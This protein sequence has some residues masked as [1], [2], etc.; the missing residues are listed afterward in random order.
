M[1]DVLLAPGS[2]IRLVPTFSLVLNPMGCACLPACPFAFLQRGRS[3]DPQ[4]ELIPRCF[5][6]AIHL[7]AGLILA[8]RGSLP[9]CA[10]QPVPGGRTDEPCCLIPVFR[11]I[12]YVGT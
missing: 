7:H 2:P 3:N 10:C 9:V 1:V 12:Q 6:H 11:T 8:G 4:N 5:C